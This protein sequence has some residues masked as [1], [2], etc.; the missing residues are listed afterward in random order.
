M[1][2]NWESGFDRLSQKAHRLAEATGMMQNSFM[3]V[4]SKMD[5]CDIIPITQ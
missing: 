3:K 2:A 5:Y 1:F 4:W